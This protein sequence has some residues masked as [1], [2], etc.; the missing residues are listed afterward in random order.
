MEELM[1]KQ[2]VH[3]ER[4]A[5]LVEA[6]RQQ[7]DSGADYPITVARLRELAD[8]QATD[9][10]LFKALSK[11]STSEQV[12]LAA[13]KDP[14]SPIALAEDHSKLVFSPML[15]GYALGKLA[16]ADKPTHTVEKIAAK[17]DK[18][19]RE[20][21]TNSVNKRI[22]DGTLPEGVGKHEA[23]GKV[24]LYLKQFPPP[25]P[26]PAKKSPAAALSEQLLATLTARREHGQSLAALADLAD[27][28]VK[29]SLV[30]KAV[31][32]EPFHSQAVLIPI[33]KTRTL[34]AVLADRDALLGSDQLLAELLEAK[35]TAKKP[36][37]TLAQLA[38]GLPED[39]RETF[40]SA[41]EARLAAGRV[42]E[43]I[44]VRREG[45][46][47]VLCL[48]NRL[49]ATEVLREQ[50]V[51]N[52]VQR[53][54]S[55]D[56]PVS[57]ASILPASADSEALAKLVKDKSFKSA[58]VQAL[59]GNPQAPVALAGDHDRLAGDPRLV[60]MVLTVQRTD[61]NQAIPVA[62]LG[63][64]LAQEV[65]E[66]FGKALHHRL[67][68]GKLP[69]GVGTLMIKKKPHLFLLADLTN[70]PAA[71]P[72]P[73]EPKKVEV[74]PPAPVIDF[75]RMFDGAFAKLNRESHGLVSLVRLRQEVPVERG[76][77]DEELNHL[78]RAGRYTL[79]P[80]ESRHGVSLEER[81]AGIVEQG[82]L[83]LYVS[84]REE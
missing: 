41:Q 58:V 9:E 7:R 19:L 74:P 43:S 63:K 57:L 33:S 28:E 31:Q 13:K 51:S 20:D 15:L 45:D 38:E 24:L 60:E 53:R 55:G 14:S 67:S 54:E 75:A 29:P 26:P 2:D 70:K 72:P 27:P 82:N 5:K 66:P 77:F 76:R 81:E 11:K 17:L 64:K 78:R 71:P 62:D 42:P 34:A 61:D 3:A 56:Y 49:P 47:R 80:A 35:T 1:P 84:K 30:K 16:S 40:L 23:K 25:P 8:P 68:E 4:G 6:L 79:T 10:E 73:A 22:A 21:F 37:T 83:L 36:F 65:K 69:A 39:Q 59:P 12:V 32:E 48:K 44:L 18:D 50:V 46:S 52:L